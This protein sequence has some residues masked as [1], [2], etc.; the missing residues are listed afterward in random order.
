MPGLL[1][2][3]NS[4]IYFFNGEENI[5]NLIEKTEERVYLSFITKIELLCFET[6]DEDVMK[7]IYEF[8][9]EVEILYIDD[10]IITNTIDCRKNMKLKLPDAIIAATAKTKALP[11]VTADKSFQKVKNIRIIS[12][13]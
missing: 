10:E 6:A 4:V 13:I 7:K 2:D 8:I 3:T 11:L 9:R 12:P 1:L 5:S